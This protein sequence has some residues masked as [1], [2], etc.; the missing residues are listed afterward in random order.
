[1]L[2]MVEKGVSGGIC[3]YLYRNAKANNKYMKYYAKNKESSYLQ[4]WDAYTLYGWGMLLKLPVSNFA[5]IKDISQFN[6]AF[7]RNYNKESDK[8]YFLE[9][10][11]Q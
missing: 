9:V 1:M 10:D 3:Y 6:E 4:Y 5:W 8:R 2:F 7:I 11:V